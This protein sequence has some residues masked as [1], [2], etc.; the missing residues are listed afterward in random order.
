MK[1]VMKD[2]QQLMHENKFVLKARTILKH[3][4]RMFVLANILLV[5]GG[6]GGTQS[7]DQ[8][9]Q[10]ADQLADQLAAQAPTEEPV[11][12]NMPLQPNRDIPL[13]GHDSQE[14]QHR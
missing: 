3:V 7:G 4:V 12:V 11:V 2:K 14:S 1:I 6:A 10:S 13:S 5:G 8:P 9:V